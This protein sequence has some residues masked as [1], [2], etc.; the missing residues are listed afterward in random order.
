M[1]KLLDSK[2]REN[3]RREGEMHKYCYALESLTFES[4]DHANASCSNSNIDI[5]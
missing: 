2:V 3:E 4:E 1:H 5:D